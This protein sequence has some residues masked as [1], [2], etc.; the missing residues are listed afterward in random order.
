MLSDLIK[1]WYTKLKYYRPFII[2]IWR[3]RENEPR[4]NDNNNKRFFKKAR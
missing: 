4:T 1:K 2:I 3:E